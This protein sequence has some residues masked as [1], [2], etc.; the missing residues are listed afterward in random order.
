MACFQCGKC[1]LGLDWTFTYAAEDEDP[2]NPSDQI[3]KRAETRMSTYGLYYYKFKKAELAN[4]KIALT[5]GVGVCQ[6]LEFKDGKA[7]CNIY[8][9]RPLACRS[10]LCDSAKEGKN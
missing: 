8:D 6:H 2:K 5:F 4:D 3:L 10:Y 9:K 1:C 7:F